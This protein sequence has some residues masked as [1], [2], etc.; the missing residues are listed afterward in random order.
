MRESERATYLALGVLIVPRSARARRQCP[1]VP[2]SQD[3]D[4]ELTHGEQRT[5][6]SGGTDRSPVELDTFDDEVRAC[7]VRPEARYLPPQPAMRDRSMQIGDG[8]ALS[9]HA[10]AEDVVADLE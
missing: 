7:K 2:A 6:H 9:T 8:L 10:F 5:R 3:R 1:K 4:P